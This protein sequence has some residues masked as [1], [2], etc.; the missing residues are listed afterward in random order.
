MDNALVYHTQDLSQVT[1]LTCLFGE[2]DVGQAILRANQGLHARLRGGQDDKRHLR[3]PFR[4]HAFL[5]EEDDVIDTGLLI[6]PGLHA[7]PPLRPYKACVNLLG[8]PETSRSWGK[9]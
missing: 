4:R 9:V 1:V 3:H 2:C 7:P 8:F 5:H 6:G